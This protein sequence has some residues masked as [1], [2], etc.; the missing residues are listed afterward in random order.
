MCIFNPNNKETTNENEFKYFFLLVCLKKC[1]Y[2][3]TTDFS[4]MA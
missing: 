4:R 3:N 1:V 2:K